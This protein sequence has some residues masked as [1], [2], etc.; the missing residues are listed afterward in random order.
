M[1]GEGK[2]KGPP[3][4]LEALMGSIKPTEQ[5]IPIEQSKPKK[6]DLRTG[7]GLAPVLQEIRGITRNEIFESTF[8]QGQGEETDIHGA[9]QRFFDRIKAI[10]TGKIEAPREVAGPARAIDTAHTQ[11]G[12]VLIE[13]VKTHYRLT[14]QSLKDAIDQKIELREKALKRPLKP[15]ERVEFYRAIETAKKGLT[16]RS[17]PARFLQQQNFDPGAIQISIDKALGKK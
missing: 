10:A 6:P 16:V 8:Q 12:D 5:K 7:Q 4:D 1:D 9:L 15:E 2:D 11:L 3:V 13:V 17:I 14:P